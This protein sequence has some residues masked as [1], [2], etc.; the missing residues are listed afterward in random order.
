MLGWATL[1]EMAAPTGGGDPIEEEPE[2]ITPH[3][4]DQPAAA[5]QVATFDEEKGL[6]LGTTVDWGPGACRFEACTTPVL[7]FSLLEIVVLEEVITIAFTASGMI[8]L[9]RE[10]ALVRSDKRTAGEPEKTRSTDAQYQ[11]RHKSIWISVVLHID[12]G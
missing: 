3:G 2:E 1:Q 5:S 6:G 11:R 10:R 9:N 8:T 4:E 12:A 7:L